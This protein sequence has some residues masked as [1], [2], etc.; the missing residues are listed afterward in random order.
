MTGLPRPI[1]YWRVSTLRCF[2]NCRNVRLS[3]KERPHR[4]KSKGGAR[5]LIGHKAVKVDGQIIS[6]V[7]FEIQGGV[8]RVVE[9]GKTRIAQV[10]DGA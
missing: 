8:H 1:G 7:D 6:D 9:V 5:R 3:R 10:S 2:Q 4:H